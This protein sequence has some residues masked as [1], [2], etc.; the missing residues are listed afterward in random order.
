MTR[1]AMTRSVNT[2]SWWGPAPAARWRAWP[3]RCCNR[4]W[5]WACQGSASSVISLPSRCRGMPVQIRWLKAV[6]AHPDVTIKIVS[7]GRF[8]DQTGPS[9]S[10]STIA[11]HVVTTVEDSEACV[12]G[13]PDRLPMVLARPKL[14]TPDLA[15]LAFPSDRSEEV[16][17]GGI[18]VSH[19]LLQYHGRHLCQPSP[20]VG[21]LRLG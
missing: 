12:A 11:H 8:H 4:D 18:Q 3:R 14:R 9:G 13:E 19:G 6:R 5:C 20:L 21:L 16:A 7:H 1:V 2:S 10:Q 17:V 15:A